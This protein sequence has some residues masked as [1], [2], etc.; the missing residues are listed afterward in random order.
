MASEE[1]TGVLNNLGTFL[2]GDLFTDNSSRI[3]YSTDASAYKEK[4]LAVIRPKNKSDIKKIV[5]FASKYKIPIIPRTAGTSLAGQVVG[6]G[7]VVDVS[8]YM[9]NIIEVN[10]KE[11]WVRV[12]P[13]VVLDELNKFL[14]PKGLFFGPE[15]STS[16]RCMIG[17]M[18]GNNSCGAHSLIYGSTRDH[19]L[20]LNVI[21]SDGSEITFKSLSLK[22]FNQK[23]EGDSLEN[24]IYK[25]I[26][27]I[28]SVLKN[29]DEIKKQYP[30]KRLKRRNTGYAI[31][32]LLD[33]APFGKADVPF[34]FCKLLA[35]S[36]G[37]L[38]FTT[39]IKLNLVPIPPKHIGLVCI[40]HFTLKESYLANLIALKYN[41]TSIELIDKAT[42]D[43]TK[44]NPKL[45]KNRFFIE[46]EPGAVLIVEFAKDTKEEIHEIAHKMEAEMRQN[47]F[48]YHFPVVFDSESKK[49][50]NLRKA[51][52][53]V[54][55]TMP[56]NSKPVPVVE[57]T[58]VHP[59]VFPEYMTEFE[60]ILK[61]NN[62]TCVYYGHI[63]TGELHLKPVLNLKSKE[64]VELFHK[65]A[66]E[67]AHLVKRYKGSLSGEHGDGRLRGEFIPIMIGEHCYNL[68]K[69]IK[70]TWDPDHIFN[71]GKITDTPPMN[72]SLRHSV[73]TT[74]R[75]TETIFDF[76]KDLGLMG[77]ID[78]CEGSADCRKSAIVGGTMC[79]SYMA[80][81]NENQTTR[82]RANMLREFL[83]NSPKNN[84]FNHK[85]LYE[86][87][88]KCIS[89]KA[90]KTECPSSVDMAKL[91]AEFLQHYYDSNGIPLR[92]KLFANLAY[93]NK[94]LSATPRIY[95]TFSNLFKNSIGIA[96]KRNIPRLSKHTFQHYVKNHP[97]S[98]L[99]K[100]RVYLFADEF[101]NYYDAEIGKKAIKLLNKLD[102]EVLV[103]K[104]MESA[105]GYISKGLIRTAKKIAEKNILFLRDLINE[106]TPLIGIEPSAILA[107]R[108]E[109]PELVDKSLRNDAEQIA[110]HTYII[111]EFISTECAKGNF[112][113]NAFTKEKKEIMV[114]GHCQQKAIASVSSTL[115]MLSIPVNYSVKEIPSGCCGMAGSFGYEKEHY[116]LSMQIGELVLFPAIR[117]LSEDTIIAAAG[118]SCRNQI[119]DGT[120]RIAK[121]PVEI[122]WEALV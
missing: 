40:H 81:K 27:N 56:G 35:G 24:K 25:N 75:K 117:K 102:Y 42:L 92:T 64:G 6:N 10:E 59:E 97:P 100:R 36:E 112:Q 107:F 99:L 69:E 95:N 91:K 52:L 118:T 98:P 57:D 121:H 108:D 114:H 2:E 94:Y 111:D 5:A 19:T 16:N 15:T 119:S 1:Y 29:Q 115:S 88:D 106:A 46:G 101:T 79:P 96:P 84:P 41:P 104:H 86:V 90:C 55:S 110:K 67:T 66:L 103:P 31:D 65:I 89:C 39:E 76:S 14:A 51:G 116:E 43:L 44:K 77:A 38:A 74:G 22:E 82:A 61:K 113:R 20:E 105:R 18:V 49:V 68:L 85:E 78:K 80:S 71:P 33:S 83:I 12:E 4:P 3:I 54:L 45:K 72:T 21:L 23:C 8:K 87:L 34:N 47:K 13:G 58:A 63:A 109:Y 93:L 122:L 37:T 73:K 60:K 32:V 7:I 30:D 53:G 50:W 62:L 11:H 9:T 28:L 70:N 26:Y 17:G 120:G 48:G